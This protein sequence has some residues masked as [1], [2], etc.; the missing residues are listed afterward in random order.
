MKELE[1]PRIG[2][3][4]CL[5][6]HQVRFD[7]GHKRHALVTELAGS[8]VD[9][10]PV[11]PEV[12]IG[13][14]TP[15]PTIQLRRTDQGTR[16]VTSKDPRNDLTARMTDY[17]QK[18]VETL[19]ELDGFIFKKGSP[20]CGMT[21]VPVVVND[22]GYRE[23]SGVGLFAEAFM[24]R[25]PLIPVE[26]EGRLND[27]GLRENFFERV[28]AYQRWKAIP[29]P[30]SNVAGLIGFHASHKL[31]LMA[32]GSHHYREL[33]RLVAG[34]TRSSLPQRRAAYIERFM[35]VMSI[36]PKRG[37]H[38][39]VLQH[40]QGYIKDQLG[41]EDKQELAHLYEA[42]RQRHVPLVTPITL[43]RH[44]L[45]KHADPYLASQHYLAP[46]PDALALRS[47]L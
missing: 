13:L 46:F 16:L 41:R 14:G 44:H 4:A 29:A 30:A 36:C 39:N 15:R 23:R 27:A 28:F 18:R 21:R 20:S 31:Q 10:M 24:Q 37:Q 22:D 19:G 34:T 40:I 2:T 17:A 42:F 7:G 6:G 43:L 26:E 35:Q 32:R 33:G 12:E 45:R 9:F 3:S 38:V 47:V 1:K 25:W 11:C 8:F 5:L